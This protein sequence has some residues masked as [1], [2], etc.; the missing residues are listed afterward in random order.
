MALTFED[1]EDWTRKTST[2]ETLQDEL[3][4]RTTTLAGLQE[5]LAGIR[6]L[7]GW[8]GSASRAA[9]QSFDPVD[10]DI[11]NA[12]AAVGAVRT[13][14]GE[15]IAE[16]T[17]LRTAISEAKQYASAN[18][19]AIQFNG[20]V[21][22]L[23]DLDDRANATPAELE[24]HKAAEAEL[25]TMVS[26]IVERGNEIEAESARV[27][28]AA[29]SGEI[30]AD[31]LTDVEQATNAG[32]RFALEPGAEP[33]E[34]ENWWNTLSPEQQ[35]WMIDNRPDWVRNVDGIPTEVRDE[36]NR[37]WL[38]QERARL[39]DELRQELAANPNPNRPPFGM[40]AR[41]LERK[42]NDLRKIEQ[43]LDQKD[44]YLIG[45]DTSGDATKAILAVGNPDEADHV[46]VTVPGMGS[47]DDAGST[48]EGMTREGTLMQ[49]EAQT[50]L[51][52]AGRGDETVATVAWMNYD[53]PP[54]LLE[55][56]GSDAR[57]TGAA[58]VLSNY[59]ESIDVTS[60]GTE[61]PHLTL[62]GHSYGSLAAGLS[63]QE[64]ASD[65]VD[66]Y[67]AYGS[68]GF[69]AMDESQ[70]GMQQG[71]VFVMQAPDDPIRL[72]AETPWFGG[73]PADGSFVQLSTTAGTTPD[74]VYREGASGH[75]EYPRPFNA[76]GTDRLRVT[77]YN[78]AAVI[79]GLSET[80]VRK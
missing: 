25:Q 26:E 14:V 51:E 56:A 79:A 73:D 67:V 76:D 36:S 32:A 38:P 4:Q 35:E 60:T 15:T 72:V 65:V 29:N 17:E 75:S 62:V 47:Q 10:D 40:P 11:A 68:P 63:L 46:A 77:G 9:R 7:D 13:Q 43:V 45:L 27:L 59:L 54:G 78:T 28:W 37:I 16:L 1:V 49:A 58:P 39:E 21:I 70:L 66:D 2:L 61:E 20:R 3:N 34:V 12:A 57:A 41:A 53:T 18:G 64:G 50:Q 80:A 8:E 71:H 30:S 48:I 5:Q 24:Q 55:G 6:R 19:Y 74:G 31:G 22:D 33:Q 69:Y 44:T 52:R 42:I 23:W